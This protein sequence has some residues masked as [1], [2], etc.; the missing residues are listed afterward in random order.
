MTDPVSAGAAP[1]GIDLRKGGTKHWCSC[2]RSKT[3][4][5]CDGSHKGTG[6]VPLAWTV[7][8]DGKHWLCLCKKSRTAPLCDGSH[9]SKA[10]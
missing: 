3:Q 4:P 2:G 10:T 5:W 6:L 9:K 1:L 8:T 7:P